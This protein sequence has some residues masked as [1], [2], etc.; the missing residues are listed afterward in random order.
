M[1]RS[2]FHGPLHP[3]ISEPAKPMVPQAHTGWMGPTFGCSKPLSQPSSTHAS[4]PVHSPTVS[5]IVTSPSFSFPPTPPKD[6]TPETSATCVSSNSSSSS[7]SSGC[8]HSNSSSTAN[9]MVPSADIYSPSGFKSPDSS[10]KLE[11]SNSTNVISSFL[12]HHGHNPASA[13]SMPSYPSYLGTD[14]YNNGTLGFH[15]ASVFKSSS[16]SSS[17]SSSSPLSNRSRA[18]TRSSTGR[19]VSSFSSLLSSLFSPYSSLTEECEDAI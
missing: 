8:T 16:T 5:A 4:L 17:S 15:P 10:V 3:W 13:H 12:G 7:K 1:Y 6:V 2:H 14:P 18:K 11:S 9:E 19:F